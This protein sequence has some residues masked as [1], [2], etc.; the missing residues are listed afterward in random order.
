MVHSPSSDCELVTARLLEAT[1]ERVFR[2]ISD[3]EQLAQWWGPKGFT[4]TFERF[5]FVSGGTWRF[6]MHGPD[7]TDYPN[8]IEFGEIVP[9]RRVVF[10]HIGA[11]RFELTVTLT[12]Q[13]GKTQLDWNQRF[14]TAAVCASVASF[15]S[16]ANEQVL[17]R[18]EAC[19]RG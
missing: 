16:G 4:N 7:G 15:A 11:P 17:D 12:G 14:E 1:P 19:L 6:V 18:L 8:H 10:H 3:P 5:D 2:A 9:D 13:Q